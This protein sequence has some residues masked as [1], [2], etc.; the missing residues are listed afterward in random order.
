M[1]LNSSRT[2]CTTLYDVSPCD[3][4]IFVYQSYIKQVI[5]GLGT[6]LNLISALVFACIIRN[7]NAKQQNDL[8]KYLLL[9]T[10]CDTYISVRTTLRTPLICKNCPIEKI[11]AFKII[12]VIFFDYIQYAVNL[13]STLTTVA[14]GFNLLRSIDNNLSFFNRMPVALPVALMSVASFAFYVYKLF[15]FRIDATFRNNSSTEPV[16]ELKY[17]QLQSVSNI[18]DRTQS[19]LVDG[20][21]QV[22]VIALNVLTALKVKQILQNKHK[23]TALKQPRAS[24]K[25]KNADK[26]QLRLV[27]MIMA[28]STLAFVCSGINLVKFLNV[29]P[30]NECYSAWTD[31]VY[32]TQYDFKFFVYYFFNLSFQSIIDRLLV[33]CRKKVFRLK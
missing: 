10:V 18:L 22:V 7:S 6:I 24:L 14:S 3:I 33:R 13:L 21:C 17:G 29:F 19:I 26:A 4:F 23:L 8:F 32:W 11:Y 9:K 12:T 31:C 5:G 30:K 27:F 2:S 28:T 25:A 1:S 16:Y 20:A 15:D